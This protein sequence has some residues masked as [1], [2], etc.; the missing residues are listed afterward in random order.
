MSYSNNFLNKV[1]TVTIDRPLGSKHPKYGDIYPLNYGYIKGTLAPDG[2]EMDAYI[3]GVS[4]PVKEFK[5]RCIA[6]IH[7]LDDDDDKLIV[8]PEGKTF[9]DEE[10]KKQT[11]FQEKYFKSKIIRT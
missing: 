10:I 2:E 5:G 8:V 9:S 4:V 1:V 3:L 6:I 11:L 7:R